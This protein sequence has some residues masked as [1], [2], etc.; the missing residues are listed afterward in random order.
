MAR[1]NDD[2]EKTAEQSE[3]IASSI[4]GNYSTLVFYRDECKSN[5]LFRSYLIEEIMKNYQEPK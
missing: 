3:D 1:T 4:A 2:N 5:N